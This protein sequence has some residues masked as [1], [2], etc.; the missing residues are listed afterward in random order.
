MARKEKLSRGEV[1]KGIECAKVHRWARAWPLRASITIE[2]VRYREVTREEGDVTKVVGLWR[3]QLTTGL[4][5]LGCLSTRKIHWN[6]TGSKR[7][8]SLL[9][10]L[11][12]RI[13]LELKVERSFLLPPLPPPRS[14]LQAG[15]PY[16]WQVTASRPAPSSPPEAEESG[17]SLRQAGLRSKARGL[18]LRMGKNASYGVISQPVHSLSCEEVSEGLERKAG[19][20][21]TLVP[22]WKWNRPSTLWKPK[23]RGSRCAPASTQCRSWRMLGVT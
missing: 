20:V 5:L 4:S 9:A 2:Y 18:R 17:C 12:G 13:R 7:S 21:S 10:K 15:G 8:A 23:K 6:K 3:G 1:R 16:K 11:D 14:Q 22:F 19:G